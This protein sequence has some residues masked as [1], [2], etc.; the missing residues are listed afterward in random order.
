ME[1]GLVAG[2]LTV[3]S[4][5]GAEV[6]GVWLLPVDVDERLDVVGV[7]VGQKGSEQA[8]AVAKRSVE[9]ELHHLETRFLKHAVTRDL[10]RVL[11]KD[12]GPG[13]LLVLV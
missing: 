4:G 5:L 11:G 7:I 2:D 6:L 10:V 1:A 12:R 9:V 8:K 13:V 3:V